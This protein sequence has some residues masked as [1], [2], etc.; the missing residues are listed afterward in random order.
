MILRKISYENLPPLHG[1]HLAEPDFS[2]SSSAHEE[3]FCLAVPGRTTQPTIAENPVLL[4]QFENS[5]RK[6][7]YAAKLF[8]N[9]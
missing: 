8:N 5:I 2:P 9:N 3:I 4:A 1:K 6:R 7:I